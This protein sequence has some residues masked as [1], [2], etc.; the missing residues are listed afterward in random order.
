M[1][2]PSPQY[3]KPVIFITDINHQWTV[4]SIPIAY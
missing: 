3:D 1:D 4:I 2:I